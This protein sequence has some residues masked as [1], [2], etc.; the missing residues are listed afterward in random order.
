MDCQVCFMLCVM[1]VVW[2]MTSGVWC[3]M[4][5]SS[6]AGWGLLQTRYDRIWLVAFDK[7][8]R[9]D[10]HQLSLSLSITFTD[11]IQHF[12]ESSY[13][14]KSLNL[15]VCL[16]F[17]MRAQ[18]GTS[19]LAVNMVIATEYGQSVLLSLG[20]CAEGKVSRL[21]RASIYKSYLT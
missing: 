21:K 2:Y 12:I 18:V 15:N 4:S 20:T 17:H 3:V 7:H 1:C 9:I 6:A 16:H 14:C 11:W 8:P 10:K 13:T 19:V 5:Q